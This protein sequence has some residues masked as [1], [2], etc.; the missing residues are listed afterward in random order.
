MLL[1]ETEPFLNL[2]SADLLLV[3]KDRVFDFLLA[4]LFDLSFSFVLFAS[5][6]RAQEDFELRMNSLF[7]LLLK[8]KIKLIS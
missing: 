2:E 7:L 3:F 4:F 5:A 1:T 6:V 8:F